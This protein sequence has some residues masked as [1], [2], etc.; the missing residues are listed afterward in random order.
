MTPHPSA[1][2]QL[3][4][5]RDI[6]RI[7]EEG[8]N[9]ASYKFA[10]VHALAD[11]SVQ[12]GDDSGDALQLPIRAIGERFVE[13][14]WRQV[15]PWPAGETTEVL[16][17]ITGSQAAILRMVRE[18]RGK[19]GDRVDRLRA[20][21]DAWDRVSAE[22]SR[23][24]RVMPLFKLQRVGSEVHDFL[25]AHEVDGRGA[26]ATI[27]LKPGIAYCFRT[28]HPLVLDLT[29]GAWIRFVRKLNPELLGEQTELGEFL[30]G[31]QRN[32]LEAVRLPLMDFQSGSCFYCRKPIRDSPHVDHFIPWSRY[33]VDLAHNFVVAHN[34]CNLAKSDHLA[35]RP[36]LERWA[37]RNS[38][39]G[40]DLGAMAQ[41]T[42]VPASLDTSVRITRWAYGQ[43]AERRGQV[44]EAGRT[45]VELGEG[46][47]GVL[48]VS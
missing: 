28:F 34:G 26:E 24:V 17:Q 6:Q 44:W 22:V 16:S 39:R 3:R 27:T 7:L 8:L 19:Y 31:A 38:Q 40:Y 25:Y 30:F 12:M 23:V 33:P 15:T 1:H 36:H 11:L 46:W 9:T 43:V 14:Y 35:A 10:L 41:E 20:N 29:R 32:A 48:A 13:L 21:P 5:L 37:E 45:L 42:G 4:F 2:F 47:E 18:T